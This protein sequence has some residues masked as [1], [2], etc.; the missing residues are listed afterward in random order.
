MPADDN[1]RHAVP[2]EDFDEAEIRRHAF[3]A[4]IVGRRSEP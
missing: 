3:T 2:G 4:P 1:E